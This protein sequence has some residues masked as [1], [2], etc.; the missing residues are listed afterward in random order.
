MSNLKVVIA[1]GVAV[2]VEEFLK[3]CPE[4]IHTYDDDKYDVNIPYLE[5]MLNKNNYFYEEEYL[6]S[7]DLIYLTGKNYY[8]Y[9]N[10]FHY[11]NIDINWLNESI[12]ELVKILREKFSNLETPKLSVFSY[13]T[14]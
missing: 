3:S 12:D 13:H 14:Y 11:D 8:L 2:Y 7:S 1:V 4:A 10:D 6:M 5:A 9:D